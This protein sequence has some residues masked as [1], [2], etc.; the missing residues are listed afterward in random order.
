LSEQKLV[1]PLLDGFTLGNAISNHDGVQ[2]Y[3]AM[4]ENSDEKY[5]VKVISVPASQV[6]LDALL[7]TGAYKDPADAMDYF[8]AV[9]EDIKK[10]VQLLNTLSK[11][12][13][14]LCYEDIQVLPMENGRLGYE[15]YLLSSYKRSLERYLRR[16]L[17]THLEAV[18]LGLDLCQALT[19]CRRSG[20]IYVDIKP[21]NI[22]ISKNKDYRIGDLGFVAINS[23]S[24]TSL[25]GKYVSPYSPPEVRDS[26]KTLNTSVDTYGVGMV[27]YQV[28]NDGNLPK[29]SKDPAEPYPSPAN[30]DYELAEIIMKAIS[31]KVADRWQDPIEMGQALIGYMQRNT[32]NNTP[33]APP[34]AI[35]EDIEPITFA[36]K[37]EAGHPTANIA[38]NAA[39]GTVNEA[40]SEISEIAD[41]TVESTN[42]QT[43]EE[44]S[45]I[46]PDP[47]TTS[48]EESPVVPPETD[49]D[50]EIDE[51]EEDFLKLLSENLDE[52][53]PNEEIAED[54]P[55]NEEVPIE[56]TAGKKGWIT[57]VILFL[58]LALIGC[59]AYYYYQNYYLQ[60]IDHLSIDGS[61]NELVVTVDT[62]MDLSK[63]NIRCTDS[64]GNST[65]QTAVNGQTTFS[66]LLPDS[67]YRIELEPVGFH[68]LIGKTAEIFTTDALTNVVDITTITGPEDGSVI[69]NFTVIGSDPDEWLLSYSTEGEET[70]TQSFTGHSVSV[71][72][73]TVGKTY[74]FALGS[75]DGTEVLGNTTQEF[76]A[77]Q[78]IMADN[79]SIV[80]SENGTITA[81]WTQPEEAVIE[82]W[83]ARCY[84]DNGHEEIKEVTGNE[85][86]FTNINSA[87]SYTIEVTAA[88]MTQPSRV[89]ITANPITITSFTVSEDTEGQLNV[90]WQHTGSEPDGGWLLM[91]T[92]DNSETPNVVKCSDT[93]AI[94]SPKIFGATYRFELQAADSTTVLVNSYQHTCENAPVFES[95]GL[96]AEKITAYLLK[97]PEGDW[98]YDTVGND[99]FSDSFASGDPIS[100]VLRA[101]TDFYLPHEEINILYVIRDNSGNVM[102]EF[103]SEETVDWNALWFDG[104]Y[105]VAELDIPKVPSQ[106]GSY[107][108]GIYFNNAAVTSTTFSIVE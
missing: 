9:T 76:T 44:V 70:L 72:G 30:A 38:E 35:L 97:T 16:H 88:G 34:R 63:L 68:K 81:R 20:H 92:F 25:P 83:T 107:S 96:S 84:S 39:Q 54:E 21:S 17:M 78:L 73:L 61:Q 56:K 40:I 77:S 89:S 100:V 55:G 50:I 15:V 13:G 86:V 51:D 75:V 60:T 43:E 74:T 26:F 66:G 47:V 90:S 85:V 104:D 108:I 28:F 106:A 32:V 42:N 46:D 98:I 105:H 53:I 69:I 24:Y 58:V 8:K 37:E 67:L 59:V 80:S 11:L 3:P 7:L 95:S 33:L 87:D 36:D 71:K 102:S 29:P 65:T 6:Q 27:L 57:A 48:K 99:A 19:V 5:I 91:Y 49:P 23:L 22:F 41:L 45:A 10:E 101:S 12:D 52:S 79:L 18:N 103:V 82:S 94:I 4:K 62:N 31:P 93:S 14:F 64:Y 1:S 2:C